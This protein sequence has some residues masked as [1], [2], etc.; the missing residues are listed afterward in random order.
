MIHNVRPNYCINSHYDDPSLFRISSP[1]ISSQDTKPS[2]TLLPLRHSLTGLQLQHPLALFQR[3]ISPRRPYCTPSSSA[4][5]LCNHVWTERNHPYHPLSLPFLSS[6]MVT[7]M[8]YTCMD[9]R[10]SPVPC[11][12][13]LT[14]RAGQVQGRPLPPL[15]L[16][17]GSNIATR[18][19][20]RIQCDR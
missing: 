4:S 7:R 16:E 11:A 9:F 10:S 13:Q 8:I 12:M 5:L 20:N 18:M 1:S 19:I 17:V 14:A 2:S 6:R 15:F 3:K